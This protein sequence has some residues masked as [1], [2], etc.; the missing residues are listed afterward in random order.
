MW[1]NS[2]RIANLLPIP[3][4]EEEGYKIDYNTDRQWVV[5]APNGKCITFKRD[6]GLCNRM[7]YIDLRQKHE[8]IAMLETVRAN[9]KG[10][11]KKQVEKAILARRMQSM[12]AH[13][14]DEKYKELVSSQSLLDSGVNVDNKG[15]E[16]TRGV[17]CAR[18]RCS[19]AA[20]SAS[21]GG[22]SEGGQ[23]LGEGAR[24]A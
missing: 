1:L 24:R 3:Q 2:R 8:R 9:F 22:S 23:S 13:P 10:Y 6:T 19:A 4:L 18:V 14:P 16:T 20:L 15:Q 5:I 11:T 21:R 7:T 12:I 17:R